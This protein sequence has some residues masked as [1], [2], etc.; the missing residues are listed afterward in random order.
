MLADIL[1]KK[2]TEIDYLNG[3][4]VRQADSLGLRAPVNEL[5][6]DIVKTLESS[7]QDQVREA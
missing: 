5:L 4:I 7:F 6:V 1:S 2:K 3:A